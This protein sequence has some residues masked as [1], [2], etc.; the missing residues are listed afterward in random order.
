[1]NQKDLDFLLV[2][3]KE[4]AQHTEPSAV[5]KEAIKNIKSSITDIKQSLRDHNSSHEKHMEKIME[6]IDDI[7]SKQEVKDSL[8]KKADK[9][10]QTGVITTIGIVL[11]F[12]GSRVLN[13]I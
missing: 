13:L 2:N 8:D 5:T 11:T 10:V 1:M 6:K 9:W 3:I 7:P 4:I 12:V